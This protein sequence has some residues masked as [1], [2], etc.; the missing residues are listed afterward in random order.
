MLNARTLIPALAA[1]ALIALPGAAAAAPGTPQ[2]AKKGA[3]QGSLSGCKTAAAKRG[4]VFRGSMPNIAGFTGRMEMRF[5]LY[6]RNKGTDWAP[7]DVD[8]FGEWDLSDSGVSGFIIKKRVAGLLGGYSYRAVVR[9]R[10]RTD[11][12]KIVRTAKKVTPACT[13]PDTTPDLAVFEPSIVAG[14]RDDVVVY[15]AVVKN[16]G[17]GTTAAFDVVLA[18]NGVAQPPQRVGPLAPGATAPVTFQAPRCQAGTIVRF[19]VDAKAEI[20]ESTETN[21]ALERRCAPASAA[22]ASR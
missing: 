7:V 20:V 14:V 9:F 21:N 16:V 12:G 18:V 11:G 15:R 10:W 17:S 5:D 3:V 13:Q 22:A 4:A 19:T 8:G 6:A 2:G 1:A